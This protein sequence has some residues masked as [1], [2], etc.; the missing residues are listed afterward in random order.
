MRPLFIIFATLGS[1]AWAQNVKIEHLGGPVTCDKKVQKG[2][3][4]TA[5]YSGTFLDGTKFDSS[6]DTN[7]P[8]QTEIGVGKVIKGWDLGVVGMCAGEKRKLVI[9][10]ELGYG[11]KVRIIPQ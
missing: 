2:D 7:E 6:Y 8:I 9:P 5:H 3:K 1:V 10:P 4:V 11:K